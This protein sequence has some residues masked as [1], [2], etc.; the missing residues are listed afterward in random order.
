MDLKQVGTP[1]VIARVLLGVIACV[2]AVVL[3]L[4]LTGPEN[5]YT[6]ERLTEEVTLKC[7]ET[8]FEMTIP[9]GRMEQMLWDRPAPID[10]AQ[11]LTNPETGRPTMFPKSEWE[12]TVQRINDNRRA[13]AEQSGRGSS[14][15]DD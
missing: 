11:G 8:G 6:H 15:E 5:P 3:L 2:L 1:K 4:R 12:Q 14:D 9:R 13:V 10:P 7:R